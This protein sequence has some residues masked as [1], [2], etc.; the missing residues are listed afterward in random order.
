[1][2]SIGKPGTGAGGTYVLVLVLF[3][4]PDVVVEVVVMTDVAVEVEM[5][6][7]TDVEVDIEV[8]VPGTD[9]GPYLSI[10]P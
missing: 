6:V 4:L 7:T 5:V 2:D 10:K 3:V 8:V 9:S 1:M